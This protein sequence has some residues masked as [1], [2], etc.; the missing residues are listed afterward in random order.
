MLILPLFHSFLAL[1]HPHHTPHPPSAPAPCLYA[2]RFDEPSTTRPFPSPSSSSFVPCPPPS[3]DGPSSRPATSKPSPP[4]HR[5]P[6]GQRVCLV[7]A[8]PASTTRFEASSLPRV[9]RR[10]ETN[11]RVPCPTNT[12]NNRV[13]SRYAAPGSRCHPIP[14]FFP[15]PRLAVLSAWPVACQAARE[16]RASAD[17]ETVEF[18]GRRRWPLHTNGCWP[19][20][21]KGRGHPSTLRR[22]FDNDD[23]QDSRRCHQ[24]LHIR[25]CSDDPYLHLPSPEQ[26]R[27]AGAR[28]QPNPR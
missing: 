21:T 28:P 4:F 27:H 23:R 5:P 3:L 18:P 11:T 14:S 1:S 13:P 25:P 7:D 22:P 15:A 2:P 9:S 8:H 19:L 24:R 6:Y 20:H 16:T 10:N 12:G 26:S 17:T